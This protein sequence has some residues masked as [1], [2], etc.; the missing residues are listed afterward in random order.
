V[1][2]T[3]LITPQPWMTAPETVA[4]MAAFHVAG[5][6]A[7]F[8]GG[9]VR[10]AVLGR[11][12]RDIDIATPVEPEHVLKILEAAN[13]R[14]IPTGIQHGTVTAVIGTHHFEITTLR[15]D[16][17]SYGRHAKVAFTDDWTQDAARRDFTINTM[18]CDEHGN[19]YDP[20]EGLED[21]SKGCIRFVGDSE[22]RI[23][24]DVLRLLRFF[25]FY[26]EY[27]KPPINGKAL[28]A[29]RTL[30]HRLPE[31]S[32]ERIR[33]ELFRI[34]TGPNPADTITLMRAERVLDYI[35]P[36]AGD[37]GRLRM[38]AWLL[39]RAVKL[40][41]VEIHP[42][43]RM[44]ALLK[45]GLTQGELFALAERLKFSNRERN[46]LLAMCTAEPTYDHPA[47]SLPDIHAEMS[48]KDLRMTCRQLGK[49]VVVDRA[50]LQWA[51]ELAL[52]ARLPPSKTEQWRT[53]IETARD[54][55]IAPFPLK[56]RD[57]LGM[58]VD[59]GPDVGRLLKQV[60]AW[61][62]DQDFRPDRA[63]CLNKL[64]QLLK[65]NA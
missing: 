21:L 54:C 25:R 53:L 45:P 62:L 15:I 40:D 16:V 9:C 3:G 37:V 33:G 56:G 10:D 64:T 30:A 44:A 27:G 48:D 13:I 52:E 59:H 63:A 18:S 24:E 49:D 47:V 60:E 34:L 38:L 22:Q 28:L 58:G 20:Y 11:A 41:D 65:S 29:C 55:D 31:L 32:G 46:H 12:A 17:E 6:E 51:G 7:R 43:R 5:A 50:L 2:P 61:W 23:K 1:E 57:L 42:V 14:A 26:A 8:I 4:V 19:I 35:L 36:E 39:D